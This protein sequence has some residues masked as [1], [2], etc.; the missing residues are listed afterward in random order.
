MAVTPRLIGRVPGF[1]LAGY[2]R[3]F[4][5]AFSGRRRE[6]LARLEKLGLPYTPQLAQMAA[7][8]TRRRKKDIGVAQL[9]P[10]WREKARALGLVREAA[11][12]APPRPIHP[13][14]WERVEVPRV[15]TAGPAGQRDP[16]HE[17]RAG[18]A[19]AAE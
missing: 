14:T 1:E 13:L 5:E 7:L 19:E 15:P 18:A 2:D 17:A 16:E 8:H 11:A 10:A 6:I 3:S 4:L 9:V 12:L